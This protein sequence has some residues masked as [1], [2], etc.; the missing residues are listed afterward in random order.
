MNKNIIEE[1]ITRLLKQ[2]RHAAG[3]L[4]SIIEGDDTGAAQIIKMLY[5]YTRNIP[6][7]GITGSP[8]VGKSTVITHL[9]SEYRKRDKK[10]GVIVID[11]S[12]PFTGGALLGDRIRMQDHF[13]DD[14]V[15]IRSMGTRGYTGGITRATGSVIKILD[16]FGM[17]LIIIETVGAGQAEVGISKFAHT[18][19]VITAPGL[20]DDVQALK[21]G[22][23]E[24]GD[25]FVINKSDLAGAERT[26]MDLECMLEDC[27]YRSSRYKNWKIR[28]VQTSATSQKGFAE[29]YNHIETH[30]KFLYTEGLF[31][32]CNLKII[33]EELSSIIEQKLA[34][35]VLYEL[36]NKAE[37][38]RL[39]RM[40]A[41]KKTD[42][43]T[44]ADT[45]VNKL[46]SIKYLKQ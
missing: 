36:E 8:G 24:I 29:L 13:L 43:Y 40:V 21:A 32:L 2:D 46:L 42:V 34:A 19:V 31:D 3:R 25:I 16:A 17:D 11:P 26:A 20:G 33:R 28:V 39:V 1:L 7:I 45:V 41:D 14:C 10:I 6:V 4:I 27:D 44:I 15:F 30:L 5:P 9:I 38:D 37:F 18:L 23:L 22:I 12:S 35:R